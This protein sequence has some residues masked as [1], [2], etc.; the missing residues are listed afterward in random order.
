M[1]RSQSGSQSGSSATRATESA[2]AT[3]TCRSVPVSEAIQGS[4]LAR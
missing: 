2:F 4:Q 3:P 1:P